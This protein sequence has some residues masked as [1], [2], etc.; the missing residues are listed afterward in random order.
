MLSITQPFGWLQPIA[1]FQRNMSDD[2][3]VFERPS[4]STLFTF[5]SLVYFNER[6]LYGDDQYKT[7]AL[8]ICQN[9]VNL[10]K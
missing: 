7:A 1:S 10:Q 4:L 2:K 9:N 6:N 3:Y 8:F 5:T